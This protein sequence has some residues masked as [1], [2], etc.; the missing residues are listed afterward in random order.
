MFCELHCPLAANL[1]EQKLSCAG[2]KVNFFCLNC[3]LCSLLSQLAQLI[4][5]KPQ[6]INEYES[7]KAIPNPQVFQDFG[8]AIEFILTQSAR[9]IMCYFLMFESYH[10]IPV[11]SVCNV[12]LQDT[13]AVFKIFASILPALAGSTDGGLTRWVHNIIHTKHGLSRQTCMTG[14]MLNLMSYLPFMQILS[15]M[16]RVLGVTLKKNPGKK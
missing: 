5:E 12:D 16:S 4:N 1:G 3:V 11:C 10:C 13:Q 7:G 6:V 15:K 9:G 14:L 2:D 8:A